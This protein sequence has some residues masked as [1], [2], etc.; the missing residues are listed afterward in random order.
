MRRFALT[1]PLLLASC[2][3]AAPVQAHDT[4]FEPLPDGRLALGTGNR[5]P[6]FET[7][8]GREYLERQGC[9]GTTPGSE[10]P[11]QPLHHTEHTLV[12]Q[13]APGAATCWAQLVPLDIQLTPGLVEAYLREVNAP[14]TVREAWAR[15]RAAGQPWRERYVKNARIERAPDTQPAPL[16]LDIVRSTTP[17]GG[18]RFQVLREGRPLAGLALELI[19]ANQQVGIW[20]RSDA[21]G[22]VTLPALP[23]GR[24]VLRGTLL[25][26]PGDD[27]IWHSAFV[28]LAFDTGAPLTLARR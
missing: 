21:N 11:M 19:A 23:P 3:L 20:R 8:V 5:W 6:A 7:A 4:W 2:L 25:T 14:P 16:A 26:P 1:L 9:R 17:E 28:T 24:W 22:F 13:P 12:L 10:R 27:G 18:N 15:Q